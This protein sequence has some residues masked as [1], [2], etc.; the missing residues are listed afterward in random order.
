M[1]EV[2]VVK[3]FDE[4]LE[5][6]GKLSAD[7]KDKDNYDLGKTNYFCLIPGDGNLPNVRGGIKRWTSLGRPKNTQPV[8]DF[9]IDRRWIR[10]ELSDGKSISQQDFQ[11]VGAKHPVEVLRDIFE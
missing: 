1:A 7:P 6:V 8:V 10:V 2:I 9:M 11:C 3:T 5:A 4:L